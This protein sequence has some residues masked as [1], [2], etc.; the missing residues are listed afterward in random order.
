[1][2]SLQHYSTAALLASK[3]K[4][5]DL[6]MS[7]KLGEKYAKKLCIMINKTFNVLDFTCSD[8]GIVK[9]FSGIMPNGDLRITIA[10][11]PLLYTNRLEINYCGHA[12][13]VTYA[14]YGEF[15]NTLLEL[16]SKIIKQNEA[17]NK[18]S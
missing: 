14:N 9:E 1:M 4:A 16:Q 6:E 15:T 3:P 12:E 17:A 11:D 8:N 13:N 2:K 5:A 18:L 7:M 10:F